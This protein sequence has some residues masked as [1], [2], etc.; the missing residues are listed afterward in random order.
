[1]KVDKHEARRIVSG[2]HEEFEKVE[3]NITGT[4]RW[5][6]N[7]EGVFR[8]LPTDTLYKTHWSQGSTEQQA[9]RPFEYKD[10]VELTE[11]EPVEVVVIKYEPV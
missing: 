4:G 9:G 8:H 10:E 3:R 11:V 5:D 1:M 6:T 2:E 7:Y